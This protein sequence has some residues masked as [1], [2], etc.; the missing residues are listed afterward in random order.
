MHTEATAT[1]TFDAMAAGLLWLYRTP[2][3][4]NALLPWH[5]VSVHTPTRWLSF[6]PE[7]VGDR[8]TITVQVAGIQPTKVGTRGMVRDAAPDDRLDP[9]ELDRIRETLE[10]AGFTVGNVW[11]GSA[12][13]VGSLTLTRPAHP[14]LVAAKDRYRAG[15]PDH[16]TRMSTC[17]NGCTWRERGLANLRLPS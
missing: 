16:D 5:G 13:V 10:R 3:P 7:G 11:P 12:G 17:Q 14:T 15:C 6:I 1:S 8:V 4:E 2:Q 9:D